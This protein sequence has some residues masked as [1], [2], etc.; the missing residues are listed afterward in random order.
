MLF[1][2]LSVS[3]AIDLPLVFTYNLCASGEEGTTFHMYAG[4]SLNY[5]KYQFPYISV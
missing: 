4:Y 5:V 1:L 2:F 3:F